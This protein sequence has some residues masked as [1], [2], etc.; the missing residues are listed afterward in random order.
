[1]EKCLILPDQ[2]NG[3]VVLDLQIV[4]QPKNPVKSVVASAK[5][6]VNKLNFERFTSTTSDLCAKDRKQGKAC[7]T[8]QPSEARQRADGADFYFCS[9]TFVWRMASQLTGRCPA[10]FHDNGKAYCS[11]LLIK[12]A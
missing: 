4:V 8:L 7:A 6:Y 12:M 9:E 3:L 5:L 1:M 11:D 2:P 10:R